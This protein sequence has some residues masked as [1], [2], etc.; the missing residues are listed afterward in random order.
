MPISDYEEKSTLQERTRALEETLAKLEG[1]WS[2]YHHKNLR[3]ELNEDGDS[4][5]V[6]MMRDQRVE[7][8]NVDREREKQVTAKRSKGYG[9]A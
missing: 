3:G 8:S 6:I 7:V 5:I 2:G 1:R 4:W 9:R